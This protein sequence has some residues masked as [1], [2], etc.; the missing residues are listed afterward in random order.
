MAHRSTNKKIEESPTN[1]P[2]PTSRPEIDESRAYRGPIYRCANCRYRWMSIRA[3]PSMWEQYEIIYFNIARRNMALPLIFLLLLLLLISFFFH[4]I[5]FP[6]LH[7]RNGNIRKEQAYPSFPSFSFLPFSYLILSRLIFFFR[8]ERRDEERNG[9][10]KRKKKEGRRKRKGKKK[11]PYPLLLEGKGKERREGKGGP[12]SLALPLLP[13]PLF[14]FPFFCFPF[15]FCYFLLEGHGKG[16]ERRVPS[17][18]Y[19]DV[20]RGGSTRPISSPILVMYVRIVRI[21]FPEQICAIQFWTVETIFYAPEKGHFRLWD[22]RVRG[23]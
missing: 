5:S 10:R 6:F 12:P 1:G 2:T 3:I 17:R 14:S 23:N 11:R 16:A 9:K 19:F 15:L 7:I 22:I 20:V 4:I 8:K 13:F 18:R 21:C